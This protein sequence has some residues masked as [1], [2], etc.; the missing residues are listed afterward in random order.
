METYKKIIKT[1][2][3]A[4]IFPA[5]MWAN[6]HEKYEKNPFRY[7]KERVVKKNFKVN[8]DALMKIDNAYGNVS[9]SSWNENRIEMVITIKAEGSDEDR[10]IEKIEG[11]DIDFMSSSS[12][13]SAKTIFNNKRSGWSW[14]WGK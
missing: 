5:F 9:I 12:M 14:N 7:E 6:T 4:L 3:I 11:V 2:L 13:V 8:A 1:L 10:V